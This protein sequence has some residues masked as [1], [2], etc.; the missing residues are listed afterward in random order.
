M[1]FVFVRLADSE[2][3]FAKVELREGESVAWLADCAAIKCGW[4]VAPSRVRLFLVDRASA[5]DPTAAEESAALAKPFLQST[6]LFADVGVV[7][8]SCLLARVAAAP[9]VGACS[10]F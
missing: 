10:A 1:A 9:V 3:A 7:S 5:H 2:D 4:G 6:A 8:S